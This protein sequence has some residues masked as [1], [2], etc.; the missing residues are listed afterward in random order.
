MSAAPVLFFCVLLLY[1]KG[2]VAEQCWQGATFSNTI[3]S[4]NLKSSSILRVPEVSSLVHCA[5]A[6]CDLPGCD[7]AWYFEHRCYVLSCQRK[8]NCQ[9]K[10]RPGT[11]SYVAFL[12]RGPPQTLVLQSLVRGQPYPGRWRPLLRPKGTEALE[13]LGLLDG[14]QGFD[15]SAQAEIE[16]PEGYRS[17]EDGDRVRGSSLVGSKAELKESSGYLDWPSVPGREGLNLSEAG[18]S[19]GEKDS[20]QD[21]LQN[22]TK[23][24]P[25]LQGSTPSILDA[26]PAPLTDSG[27]TLRSPVPV[28]EGFSDSDI[29]Q[30]VSYRNLESTPL[31]QNSSANSTSQSQMGT[32]PPTDYLPPVSSTPAATASLQPGRILLV[33]VGE[34]VAVSLPKNSVQLNAS[35]ISEPQT[36]TTYAYEWSLISYPTDHQGEMEGKHSKSVR[37]SGLSTGLYAVKV[38]VTGDSAYGEGFVNVT[39]NAAT[40]VN[41]PPRAIASPESQEVTLPAESVFIDGSQ[42]TD[43]DR[44]ASYHWE[45]VA[46]PPRKLT[47][48]ADTATLRLSD[49]EAGNYTF[50]LTVVDSD[51]LTDSTLASVRA[52][53]PVDLPPVANAGPNQTLTLPL[54]HVILSGSE[55]SDDHGI[56]D[57]SWTFWSSSQGIDPTMQ[58]ERTPVLQLFDLQEGQYTFQLTVTDSAGQKASSNV[59]VLVQPEKNKG[60]TAVVGPDRLLTLPVNSTRLDGSSSTDDQG[61]VTFHWESISSPPGMKIEDADKPVAMATGLGAGSYIFRLTVIDQQGAADSTSLTVTVTEAQDHSPEAHASGSHTLI[62]PNNSLVLRGSVSGADPANVSYLWVR[63]GQSPA[64]GDVLY[65]SEREAFLHLANLVEGT[66]LFHLSVTD[67]Q[68]RTSKATA[69]VELRPDPHRRDEVELELQVAVSQVSQ[70]QRDTVVRQL[71]ALLHVLDSDISVQGLQAQ[72]DVS[73]TLRFR[74]RGRD[75]PMPG[76]QLTRL[77]RLLLLREKADFL[78]FRTLRVDTAMCLLRC[79]DHGQCEPFTKRCACDPFWMENLIRRFLGDGVSNCE[80]SV[81][82]VVLSCFMG[83]ILV[84]SVSWAC[85]FCCKR[86]RRTKVRK[87]T[88]YTILDDMDDQERMELRPKYSLKHRSTEHNSSLMM[89]ESEFDSEQDTIFTRERPDKGKRHSNGT[90]KNG[91]AFGYHTVDG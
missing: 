8:E 22:P 3:I 35:V 71:A 31:L 69:T 45:D 23:S 16:Y 52:I 75:G 88:K 15:D 33:S 85:V 86:R 64:A 36:K 65:G 19:Q 38:C 30:N 79:S 77:L 91:D 58:G 24:S 5:E 74:V 21:S 4:P 84:M 28:P 59:T 90:T 50:R 27:P 72:S 17:S 10:Q 73:T 47:G 49:L 82:Y 48:S 81:L 2:A 89:S 37:L 25:F 66:Y 7:L 20:P 1:T 56:T 29:S 60:P 51:G 55:S 14:V 6:C 41:Q 67:S 18:G 80:W 26:V 61:I 78:L 83:I 13:D 87:K 34:P 43:D 32:L 63:D 12:Q 70:Q 9:P 54:N 40:H 11:D 46:S 57:Y 62:L 42:S 39:I 53:R 76:P 44:V 68:S